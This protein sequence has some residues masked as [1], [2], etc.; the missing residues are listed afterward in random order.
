MPHQPTYKIAEET[1]VIPH[2]IDYGPNLLIGFN[3]MLIRGKEPILVDTGAPCAR[4]EMLAAFWKLVDPK[5]VRWVF[6]SHDDRDHLGNLNEVLA[7]APKAKAI[8]SWN[9]RNKI[10]PEYDIAPERMY[11]ANDGD[12][13]DAGDRKLLALRP[14]AYDSPTTRALFNPKTRVLFS[15]D[16]FGT[17]MPKPIEDVSELDHD[18]H[19]NML[20]FFNSLNHPWVLSVDQAKFDKDIARID[21]LEAD[22]VATVHGPTARGQTKKLLEYLRS[23]P[24]AAPYVPKPQSDLEAMIKALK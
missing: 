19:R 23:A 18:Y 14:P 1:F 7:A 10:L 9:M 24:S 17:P 4:E 2:Y 22:I 15:G 12:T 11:W 6:I 13:V 20:H 5:D 3:A 21:A 8:V 16:C